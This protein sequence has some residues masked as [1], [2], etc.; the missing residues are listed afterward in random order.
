[1]PIAPEMTIQLPS[2]SDFTVEFPA[3]LVDQ[4]RMPRL[5]V[6]FTWSDRTYK[7][8]EGPR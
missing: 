8:F 2:T 6:R 7:T 3:I 4:E 5:T 1:M